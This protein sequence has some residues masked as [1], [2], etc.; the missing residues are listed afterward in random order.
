[1]IVRKC[2][3]CKIEAKICMPIHLDDRDYDFCPE[4]KRLFIKWL[5]S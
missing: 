2:D 4:C 3:K 1:M 5:N